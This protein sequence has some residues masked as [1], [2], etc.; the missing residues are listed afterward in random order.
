MALDEAVK[1]QEKQTSSKT[2]LASTVEP[3]AVRDQGHSIDLIAHY[4]SDEWE[5]TFKQ[6]AGSN[7]TI[8]K[9]V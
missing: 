1:A 9:Q 7:G 2:I 5:A 4:L 3:V 8:K 6:G